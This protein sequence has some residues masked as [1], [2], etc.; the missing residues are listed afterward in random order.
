MEGV[1]TL[2]RVRTLTDVEG[3]PA[4]TSGP[5]PCTAVARA[6]RPL[7]P[8]K[9]GSEEG[10]GGLAAMAAVVRFFVLNVGGLHGA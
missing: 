10:E 2:L 8:G 3:S 9:G 5:S 7:L 6:P 4:P 1:S